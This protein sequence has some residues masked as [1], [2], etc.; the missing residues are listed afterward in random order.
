MRSTTYPLRHH[1]PAKKSAG[2]LLSM[3]WLPQPYHRT[4]VLTA[5]ARR[6]PNPTQLRQ[7][8]RKAV[9][10]ARRRNTPLSVAR[11]LQSFVDLSTAL[12]R[13]R[14]PWRL[15]RS[16]LPGARTAPRSNNQGRNGAV[17][18]TAASQS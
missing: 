5:S 3:T 11:L 14:L 16:L 2:P 9:R 17:R 15:L 4:K 12:N 18:N 8:S 1:R 13:S 6:S 7:G 10:N